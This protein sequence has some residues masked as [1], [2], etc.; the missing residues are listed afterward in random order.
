MRVLSVDLGTSNTVAVLSAHGLPP[1]V[2]EVDGSATMPSAVY[3]NE[4]GTLLV[5]R[6]AERQ[7]R[8]DPSRFEPN[9]KRRIDE[10]TLLLG[11]NVITVTDALAAV[12]ERV[13]KETARQLNGVLPDEVRLTHPAQ[14]GTV[15]RNA[16]VSAARLAGLGPNLVLVPEPVA[17]AAH[18]ASFPD[19]ELNPGQ[20]LAVYDLGAGTFDVAVVGVT[21]TGFTVLAED[22]LPD[23]GGLDVD[24]ALL[25]HVGRE[26]SFRDPGRWQRL[27]RPEST[28]DRRARRTL[29]EDVREA[30]EA[31]SRHPQ[32][33]VPMPEEF[34]D[35]LVT[36]TE[37]E[38]LI[39]PSLLRSVDVLSQTIQRAGMSPEQLAG[40]F[41]VGGSSRIPL[42]AQLIADRLRVVP[43]SLDQPETA[44]AM[45]AYHVPQDDNPLRTQDVPS[46]TAQG[47]QT[48]SGVQTASG[49][50]AGQAAAAGYAAHGTQGEHAG[51]TGYGEHAA[52][53]GLG[54]HAEHAAQAGYGT[55]AEHPAQSGYSAQAEHGA[56]SGYS[57]AG[58][59]AQPGH[60]GYPAQ[61]EHAGQAGYPDQTAYL[62]Q[63]GHTQAGHTQTGHGTQPA[64][65]TQSSHV[66]QSATPAPGLPSQSQY[67]GQQQGYAQ[68][69]Q[70][71]GGYPQ[72][73][74]YPQAAGGGKVGKGN[75]NKLLLIGIAAAV[76]VVLGVVIG[77]FAFGGTNLPTAQDCQSVG[78]ADDKGFTSC[79]RQ[80]A[81]TVADTGKCA[82]GPGVANVPAE[83]AKLVGAQVSCSV[84][85]ADGQQVQVIYQQAPSQ[86]SADMAAAMTKQL[87][88]K[89]EKVEA[90]WQGNGLKGHYSAA[91]NNSTGW[92]VFTVEGRPLFG[93]V[94]VT[95]A[96]AGNANAMADLFEQK[97]QPGTS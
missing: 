78:S 95:G 28:A 77:V 31:L 88:G 87:A 89:G 35:V 86:Q 61:G 53:A 36:R 41:L 42:V 24:H 32:T 9:P 25:I 46:A 2:I 14:W 54:A 30:K 13:A 15:R 70:Y 74:G 94:N 90:P 4:D 44:V 82:K 34:S 43:V 26:V 57:A 83:V 10:T 75:K 47:L 97:I 50:Q 51:Q 12:L 67:P 69:Q 45:G 21:P 71:P 62:D 17:A 20:A 72:G 18:F 3:A 6:D 23:L 1:R 68:Q 39:R 38:A 29:L 66:T 49:A 7:A 59:A 79:L 60:A 63:T 81:G 85:G 5:G 93:A 56:Q 27:L 96:K 80:L 19:R 8:L 76:V 91:V 65:V 40:I 58:Y 73:G 52:Q 48:G 37:L 55:H 64:H 84:S 22:G 33:E 11:T 16:L 92:V